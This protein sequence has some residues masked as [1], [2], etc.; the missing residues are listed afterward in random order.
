MK[1]Q[2]I[3]FILN[4]HKEAGQ[5]RLNKLFCWIRSIGAHLKSLY[6]SL[7]HCYLVYGIHVWS[8]ATAS[9]VNRIAIKRKYPFR[10]I[11]NSK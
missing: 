9:V 2:F 4:V 1:M 7:I 11:V 5:I 10:I 3:D 6:Y 8:S